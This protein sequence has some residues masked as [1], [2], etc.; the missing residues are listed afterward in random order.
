MNKEAP[1]SVLIIEDHHFN[2]KR[3]CSILML[4]KVYAAEALSAEEGL[5]ATHMTCWP[6]L[7]AKPSRLL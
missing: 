4:K 2:L 5:E 6:R 3:F 1:P 7:M